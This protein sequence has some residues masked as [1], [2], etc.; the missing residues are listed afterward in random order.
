[1]IIISLFTNLS[2]TCRS[3]LS[4][5]RCWL[6]S[7]F[8]TNDHTKRWAGPSEIAAH[9]R[10]HASHSFARLLDAC[11]RS[12]LATWCHSNKEKAFHHHGDNFLQTKWI[13]REKLSLICWNVVSQLEVPV[14]ATS[15]SAGPPSFS[16]ACTSDWLGKTT[17]S[18]NLRWIQHAKWLV[19][20]WSPSIHPYFACQAKTWNPSF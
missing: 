16:S 14:L 12:S 2:L 20:S 1:M 18:W 4:V 10:L 19:P 5:V 9:A 13:T 3:P 11:T 6:G 7:I 17:Y 8:L 15:F